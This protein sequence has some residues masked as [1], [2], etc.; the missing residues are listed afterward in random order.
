MSRISAISNLRVFNGEWEREEGFKP[1]L[2]LLALT[3]SSFFF[4]LS[5]FLSFFFGGGGGGSLV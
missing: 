4:F 1:Q 5:L 2:I 3:V